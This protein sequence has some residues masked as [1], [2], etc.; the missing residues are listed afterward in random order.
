MGAIVPQVSSRTETVQVCVAIDNNCS[1]ILHFI[2]N[3]ESDW[4]VIKLQHLTLLHLLPS[5]LKKPTTEV[6]TTVT[7]TG[8][9]MTLEGYVYARYHFCQS[10]VDSK[11]V[12]FRDIKTPLLSINVAKKLNIAHINTKVS[13]EHP[14]FKAKKYAVSATQNPKSVLTLFNKGK[15]F[16][17]CETHCSLS[18]IDPECGNTKLLKQQILQEYDDIFESQPP[19]KDSQNKVADSFS[20]NP[21]DN[22]DETDQQHA[23]SQ[24]F[25]LQICHLV[26]C[27]FR[28]EQLKKI[29]DSNVEYQLLKPKI[30]QGFP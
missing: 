8:E 18:T 12:V 13:P 5:Q 15:V 29:A 3:A 2:I 27:L 6:K 24:A 30:N 11:L 28:L 21:V 10:Y 20:R 17:N 22:P 4:T 26:D 23:D 1:S 25:F 19:T 14:E 7:V 9:K 16:L